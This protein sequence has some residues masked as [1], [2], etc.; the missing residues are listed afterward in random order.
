VGKL[1][2]AIA[3]LSKELNIPVV[4]VAITGAFEALPPGRRIPRLF[5]HVH[6][7]FMDPIH[8]AALTIEEI[9]DRVRAHILNAVEQNTRQPS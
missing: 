2:R 3:I 5:T 4:P 8:P 7:Q 6:I 9:R 1:K